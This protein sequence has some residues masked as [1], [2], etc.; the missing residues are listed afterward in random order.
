MRHLHY[1]GIGLLI[2]GSLFLGTVAAGSP[3]YAASAGSDEL[4]LPPLTATSSVDVP[5]EYLIYPDGTPLPADAVVMTDAE[6]DALGSGTDVSTSESTPG[7]TARA[8]VVGN[9]HFAVGNLWK[10]SSAKGLPSGGVGAKPSITSCWGAVKKTYIRS[11]VFM[12]NGWLWVPV[13]KA[14]ESF[15]TWNMEQKSV[16]YACNGT[17]QHTFR[18]VSY[19]KASGAKDVIAA[20][21]ELSS[22]DYKLQCG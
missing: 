15:G 16:L 3:A 6:M 17:G 20:E 2:A 14:V 19:F 21:A 8:T 18:V 11:V 13:T 4:D 7:A 10:R 1:R 9:C 5:D 22:G 12:H